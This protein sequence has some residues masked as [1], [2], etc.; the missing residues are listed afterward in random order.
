MSTNN[1]QPGFSPARA[2]E[3]LENLRSAYEHNVIEAARRTVRVTTYVLA[4]SVA[5]RRADQDLIQSHVRARGWK[6]A[7]S[8]FWDFGQAPPVTDRTGFGEASRYAVQGFAHA[9]IAIGPQ[10]ITTDDAMYEELLHFLG[11]RGVFLAYLSGP[12]S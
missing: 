3:R 12:T 11:S 6:L 5:E 10:A 8:S 7:L 1:G 2:D 4:S 9:I